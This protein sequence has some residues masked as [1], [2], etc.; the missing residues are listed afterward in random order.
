MT[1]L[2]CIALAPLLAACG[3]WAATYEVDLITLERCTL[4]AGEESCAQPEN[5]RVTRTLIVE[6]RGD[7]VLLLLG[8]TLFVAPG[9]GGELQARR[10]SSQLELESGCTR[11]HQQVLTL[12]IGL[13]DVAGELDS[14][15][16]TEGPSGP[17][18][19]TPFGERLRQ[20]LVGTEIDAP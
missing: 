12:R 6:P 8:D 17:C 7:Q 15:L 4:R 20:E 5:E 1:R 9:G 10:Q 13:G 16:T 18:G 3:P 11:Q 2:A 14:E 19:Q